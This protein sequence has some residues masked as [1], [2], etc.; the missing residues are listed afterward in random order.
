MRA[1]TGKL[2]FLTCLFVGAVAFVS[3][4]A[5]AAPQG[6]APGG[7]GRGA[8][9]AGPANLKVLPK[10]W[11]RQQV[12]ALMQTF[13]KSLGVT[14]CEHCHA[15]DPNVAPPPPG[16]RGRLDYALDTN[17]NKDIARKMIT[18]VMAI[19]DTYLKDVGEPSTPEKVTCFT[20][21]QGQ[22]TPATAPPD[23]WGRGS[24]SLLP[25]GPV[26]PARGA[27][28]PGGRGPA[29]PAN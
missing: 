8:G 21:H 17:P 6:G 14:G 22:E 13:T 25:A 16:G 20:C 28:A 24:F 1:L 12:G 10:T 2:V 5:P 29:A 3:A 11:T 26:L 27:G 18:M 7:Q 9:P 15:L 23:G 4:Q 19:N